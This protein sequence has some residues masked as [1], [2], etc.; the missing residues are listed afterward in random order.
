MSGPNPAARECALLA[1]AELCQALGQVVEPFVVPV[2][3]VILERYADKV[4]VLPEFTWSCRRLCFSVLLVLP[5]LLLSAP[6]CLPSCQQIHS[7]SALHAAC[8]HTLPGSL[9][10]LHGVGWHFHD[11][12]A[13]AIAIFLRL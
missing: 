1:V 6:T 5:R 7:H 13:I 3:P 10:H 4:S 12:I 8:G 11:T 9:L 2:L